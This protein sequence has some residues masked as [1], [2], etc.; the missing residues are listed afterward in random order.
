M[1]AI[2]GSVRFNNSLQEMFVTPSDSTAQ[3]SHSPVSPLIIFYTGIAGITPL[4]PGFKRAQIRPQPGMMKDFALKSYTVCGTI[5][6]KYTKGQD[7]NFNKGSMEIEVPDAMEIELVLPADIKI[8]FK[9][10]QSNKNDT[11]MNL[12]RYSISSNEKISFNV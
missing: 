9:K 5:Y 1:S 7:S 11:L 12:H 3:W 8:P 6:M 2:M 4:A 10:I